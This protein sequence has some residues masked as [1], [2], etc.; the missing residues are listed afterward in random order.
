MAK[1]KTKTSPVSLG[2]TDLTG[3][4]NRSDRSDRCQPF[5]APQHLNLSLTP[6]DPLTLPSSLSSPSRALPLPCSPPN[7]R[8]Q[9]LPLHLI[10]RPRTDQ[11]GVGKLHLLDSFPWVL[12][13]QA[14]HGE[15]FSQD[16]LLDMSRSPF[17]EG[18]MWFPLVKSIIM[19]P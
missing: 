19:N 10:P 4:G 7:P 2:R 17:L 1:H 6:N 13:I 8:A 11:I 16:I 12:W 9:N 5:W 18:F 14:L 15:S 3:L